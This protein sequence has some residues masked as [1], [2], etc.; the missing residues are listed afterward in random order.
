MILSRYFQEPEVKHEICALL[1]DFE[2]NMPYRVFDGVTDFLADL[3]NHGIKAAIVCKAADRRRWS[4]CLK[5]VP[6]LGGFF[7]RC[8]DRCRRQCRSKP[9]P[10]G[11]MRL[12]LPLLWGARVPTVM[13]LKTLSQEWKPDVVPARVSSLWLRQTPVSRL[14]KKADAVIDTFVGFNVGKMLDI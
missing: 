10:E 8:A 4:V 1:A 2:E 14:R 11:Y 3:R 9:D 12:P 5:L 13:F 6:G 7:R